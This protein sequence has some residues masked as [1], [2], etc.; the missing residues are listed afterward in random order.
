MLACAGSHMI[1]PV[2]C[3]TCGKVVGNKYDKYIELLQQDF[4]EVR[5][6]GREW[7]RGFGRP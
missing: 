6:P 4:V 5:G 7:A 2:R 1:I 3:F